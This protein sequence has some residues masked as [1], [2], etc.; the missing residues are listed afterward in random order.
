M[1]CLKL[2]WWVGS[3]SLEIRLPKLVH[4]W[5]HI[6]HASKFLGL[7]LLVP[8]VLVSFPSTRGGGGIEW[9]HSVGSV[10]L[11]IRLPKLVHF[12]FHILHAAKFLGL[13]LLV[14]KVLLSFPSTRGGGDRMDSQLPHKCYKPKT[15]RG[16]RGILQAQTFIKNLNPHFRKWGS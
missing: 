15:L 3:V 13:T 2:F 6:L 12:W 11:E 4:F 10:S 7:T 5:F 14:P 9:T 16:V 8:K 1:P